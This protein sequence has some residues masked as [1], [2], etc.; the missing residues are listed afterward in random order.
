MRVTVGR[1]FEH[2]RFVAGSKSGEADEHSSP[3]IA[4]Q[5]VGGKALET[6]GE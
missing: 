3:T 6:A 5:S 2:G 1:L 4:H